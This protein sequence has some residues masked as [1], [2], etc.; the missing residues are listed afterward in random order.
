[1]ESLELLSIVFSALLVGTLLLIWFFRPMDG[2]SSKIILRRDPYPKMSYLGPYSFLVSFCLLASEILERWIL[3][4]RTCFGYWNNVS[5]NLRLMLSAV[6][7]LSVLVVLHQFGVFNSYQSKEWLRLTV[8]GAVFVTHF[9][10]ERSSYYEKWIYLANL[11]NEVLKAQPYVLGREALSSNVY[12]YRHSLEV[13]L[14]YD[15]VSMEMWSHS[16]FYPI[17]E[18]V[19]VDALKRKHSKNTNEEVKKIASQMTKS[20]VL[21]VL[22]DFQVEYL[23]MEKTSYSD[24][25]YF[26]A[27]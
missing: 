21:K 24:N 1:M 27:C 14:V 9:F 12:S 23:K 3:L 4:K 2:V 8:F 16:S 7:S 26:R 15:M 10:H 5:S 25:V 17:F 22:H 20:E 6:L 13:A 19:L 11:Y 18:V